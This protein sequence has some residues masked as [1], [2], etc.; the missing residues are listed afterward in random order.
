MPL[1][2]P[3]YYPPS[4]VVLPP[5][6]PMSPPVLTSHSPP[7]PKP[8]F[9]VPSSFT[10]SDGVKE[11]L[12]YLRGLADKYK[13]LTGLTEPL[14]LSVKA[15]SQETNKNPVSSFSPPS[16]SKIPKFLNKPSPLYTPHQP[17]VAKNGETQDG[18]AA[19]EVTP[20]LYPDEEKDAYN[21]DVKPASGSPT[22]SPTLRTEEDTAAMAQKPSSPKTDF[23]SMWPREEKEGSPE[24][25]RLNLSHILPSLPRDN[26]GKME[27]EIPLS[28]LH[29]WL[30]LCQVESSSTM[31][32]PMQ[33][34]VLPDQQEQTGQRNSSE[35][36]ILA[37]SMP[38]HMNPQHQSP[39]A[40]DL[41]LRR[42]NVPS[43][44]TTIQTTSNHHNTSPNHFTSYKHLP[45][46]G[47]LKN[48]SSC[49]VYP[50]EQQ[51]VM[52]SYNSKPPSYWG[53]HDIETQALKTGPGPLAVH[54]TVTKLYT[55]DTPKGGK[56]RSKMGPSAVLMVDSIP[57]SVLHLTTEEVM[58]LKKI[59]SSSS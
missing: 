57:G 54:H 38:S 4:H 50:V 23:Q 53:A 22:Y 33:L 15:S 21:I 29:K 41:R 39:A 7:A 11:P 14:N 10:T 49:D 20:Y 32:G 28:V 9:T 56:E 35:T 27:I 48:A 44:T 13:H 8:Q 47:I 36:D 18:E 52:K 25:K 55:E 59:I 45:S 40:E 16:S 6:G 31:Y 34:T 2:Y 58:K 37:T 3:H 46:G 19:V 17:Q 42:R 51:D 1:H 5:Y 30:R 12:E 26:G 43:P 24:V